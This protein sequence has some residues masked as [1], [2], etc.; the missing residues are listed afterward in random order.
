MARNFRDFCICETIG[1]IFVLL[2]V[3][4]GF[5][6]IQRLNNI[7]MTVQNSA[8]NIFIFMV[9]MILF[10]LVMTP[11]AQAIWG[12]QLVGYK[13]FTD[14]LASVFLIAYSKGNLEKI[15]DINLFWA[16]IFTLIYYFIILFILHSAMHYIQTDSL[17]NIVMLNS[18]KENDIIPELTDPDQ[19]MDKAK[20]LEQKKK[21]NIGQIIRAL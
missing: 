15:L 11:L 17:R 12:N 3:V 19:E 4:D 2:K 1:L 21:E 5:R 7:V 18:L 10:N 9:I 16:F 20:Y 13:T 6:Y 14:A 8:A